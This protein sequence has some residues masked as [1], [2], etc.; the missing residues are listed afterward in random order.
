MT[1]TLYF[2]EPTLVIMGVRKITTFMAWVWG[3]INC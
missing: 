1:V 2:L 3:S